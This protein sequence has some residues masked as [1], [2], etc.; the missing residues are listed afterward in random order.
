MAWHHLDER[1]R[2]DMFIRK[3]V[4]ESCYPEPFQRGR[5]ERYAVVGLEASLWPNVEDLVSI[6]DLP[7]FGSLQKSLMVEK[8]RRRLRRTIGCNVL[9]AGDKFSIQW[10]DTS[11]DEI[12]IRQIATRMAQSKPSV[13]RS[14]KRSV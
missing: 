4:R 1:T 3:A 2:G 11:G 13:M 12:G 5:K 6:G 14:T 8:L 9:R 7:D 10:S